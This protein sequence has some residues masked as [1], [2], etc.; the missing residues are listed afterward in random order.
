MSSDALDSPPPHPEA[1]AS[2]DE[3][4]SAT[5][6]A[7]IAS[8]EDDGDWGWDGGARCDDCGLVDESALYE[9]EVL[10]KRRD[11]P[12]AL[13]WLERALGFEFYDLAD[14]VRR[15]YEMRK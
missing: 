5:T 3:G 9:A 8:A 1:P 14:Q 13:I 11:I 15:F 4:A 2:K 7:A 6:A 10:F 12:E